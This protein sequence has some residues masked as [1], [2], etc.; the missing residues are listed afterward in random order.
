MLKK[1]ALVSLVLLIVSAIDSIRNLPAAA[2]FGSSLIFFYL[3]SAVVFLF[4]VSLVAAEF[5][6][7]YSEEGGIFHWVRHA[8]GN[9]AALLAVWLQWINTLV[10]YPTIL[11]FIAGTAAFLAKTAF[12][13]SSFKSPFEDLPFFAAA[14]LAAPA[15]VSIWPC[16]FFF[17][18]LSPNSGMV[19]NYLSDLAVK[20]LKA[21]SGLLMT[22]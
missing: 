20:N 14:V 15:E 8:F 2:L 11:S 18:V 6:S 17:F 22:R 16:S 1:I 4:P 21:L 9:R 5:S 12:L 10:W 19:V 7:R 3:L 13:E